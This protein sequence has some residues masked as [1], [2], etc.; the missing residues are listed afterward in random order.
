M[1]TFINFEG[2][3]G[4]GKTTLAR[5][6]AKRSGGV[7]YYT[8]P[9]QIS[10]IRKFIDT[11]DD[12][13]IKCFY[14]MMGNAIASKDIKELLKTTNVIADRYIY[15]TIAYHSLLLGKDIE[16]PKELLLPDLIIRVTASW[17]AIEKRI[18]ERKIK[19]PFE[20]INHLKKVAEKYDR[21]FGGLNN[22][23]TIDTT[24][25]KPDESLAEISEKLS[26]YVY[27]PV[28]PL[29]KTN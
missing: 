20:E 16:A 15:T 1:A 23:I 3:D 22:V 19:N 12:A 17:E 27:S 4:T 28:T 10:G 29:H 18:K 25:K 11:S 21:I 14:Y 5:E 26:H 7:Y 2:L 8:P 6:Y 9:E 24:N 13:L